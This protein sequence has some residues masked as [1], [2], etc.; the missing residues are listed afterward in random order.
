MTVKTRGRHGKIVLTFDTINMTVVIK[1]IDSA[2]VQ[3]FHFLQDSIADRQFEMLL[4]TGADM[5][6]VAQ[7]KMAFANGLPFATTM[8]M[9]N[10]DYDSFECSTQLIP[11]VSGLPDTTLVHGM[12]FI[13]AM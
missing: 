7:L 6:K 13:D 10:D 4:A 5:T 8:L 3:K 12:L 1:F 9:R 11:L 2:F